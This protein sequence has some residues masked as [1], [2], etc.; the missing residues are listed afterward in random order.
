[1]ECYRVAA[2]LAGG[3]AT[4][5]V[6]KGAK[7]VGVGELVV[8]REFVRV[9]ARAGEVALRIGLARAAAS[10]GGGLDEETKEMGKAV[11]LECRGVGVGG[12]LQA[13]GRMIEACL[14]D[15]ILKSKYVPP[16]F[17]HTNT[18]PPPPHRLN[19]KQSLSLTSH[20]QDNHL[21]ALLLALISAHYF[22]TEV[23]HALGILGT[24][25]QFA[26]GLGA[27]ERAGGRRGGG[28][29]KEN[30]GGGDVGMGDAGG[31]AVGNAPLRLWVG[32]RFLGMSFFLS[33]L[34]VLPPA[35]PRP[36][37]TPSRSFFPPFH[38]RPLT[39]TSSVSIRSNKITDPV[40]CVTSH[41]LTE[42]YKRMGKES[43]VQKQAH[44]N[45]Q[46]AKAVEKMAKRGLASC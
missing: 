40:F 9:G 43:R 13:I 3:A 29:G 16:P 33:I 17:P 35:P 32:G 7:E 15:E 2:F 22:H 1:L 26:A 23:E 27:G 5:P 31:D 36:A 45:R 20:S 38:S 34:F 28:K 41:T 24:C 19:L 44:A 30:Q 21:R 8:A 11:V 42:L 46:L 18:N 37:P 39:S 10:A 6:E 12:T 4:P 25:E 14:S